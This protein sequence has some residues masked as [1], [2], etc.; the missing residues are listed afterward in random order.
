MFKKRLQLRRCNFCNKPGHNKATCP[1]FLN[2]QKEKSLINDEKRIRV[3]YHKPEQKNSDTVSPH[4]LSLK[5]TGNYWENLET[6]SPEPKKDEWEKFYEEIKK[7]SVT[8]VYKTTSNFILPEKEEVCPSFEKDDDGLD[9]EKMVASI[10]RENA[11]IKQNSPKKQINKIPKNW[12]KYSFLRQNNWRKTLAG[13][14][15][16]LII[17]ALPLQTRT[18]Y[19]NIKTSTGK[20]TANST[21]GFMA[22]QDSTAAII[23]ADL[24]SAQ[25]SITEALQKFNEAIGEIQNHKILQAVVKS[26]PLVSSEVQSRQNLITAGQKIALGNTYLIKGI[27]EANNVSSTPLQRLKVISDHLNFAIPNYEQAFE[28]LNEVKLE[29]LPFEYQTSFKDFKT[30]FGGMLSDLK[31]ISELGRN[32]DEIFG[33]QG[34]RRYLLVFQNEAELRGT[35]GFLGSFAILEIKDGKIQNLEIPSGGSYDLQ[36]QLS[37]L[38]EPPAPLLLSNKKWEFQDANWFPD[39][40]ASA[41]KMLWFYRY[42]RN[43]TLDGAIAI[44]SSVLTRLLALIGPVSDEQR[45]LILDKNNALSSLQ[46]V[47]EE[48]AEKEIN[49]PKQVLS[50]LGPQILSSLLSLKPENTLPLL[51]NLNE[52][53]NQKEIQAYFTAPTTQKAIESL[54]WGGRIIKTPDDRDYLMVVNSNIQGQKSDAQIK[55][56]IYHQ[57][58]VEEDGSIVDS[59]TITRNHEGQ[60]GQKFYGQTN[61]DYIRIYVPEG[62][63]LISAQGFTWPDEKYFR[64]PAKGAVKDTDLLSLEQEIGFDQISGT[65]ITKEFNKTVFGNWIITEPGAVNTIQFIYRLPFKAFSKEKTDDKKSLSSL[66]MQNKYISQYQLLVQKQSGCRSTF[67]SQVIYPAGWESTWNDGLNS[68]LALNGHFVAETS[69]K[70]DEIWSLI[71]EKNN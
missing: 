71:M 16:A 25:G 46:T 37:V 64:A 56:K 63:E 41:E 54:G 30:L 4:L 1:E 48:G 32:I 57:A 26:I 33:G 45:N 70:T 11:K 55:Q 19:Q 9:F 69:L 7:D 44:N 8:P 15:M 53:L 6:A 68:G 42:S 47:V 62:A 38:V 52:A 2:L 35:G 24:P 28:D 49:K 40:K 50:D 51:F 27:S 3:F 58:L 59:V 39:F 5:N 29:V 17:L 23:S 34:L 60:S 65:R 13:A 43:I 10:K 21:E 18:F 36:G 67:E 12:I 31:N 22:L 14:M 20:I 66:L 61:I